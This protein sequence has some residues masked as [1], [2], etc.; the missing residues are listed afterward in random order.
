M[1]LTQLLNDGKFKFV[2]GLYIPSRS[3]KRLFPGIVTFNSSLNSNQEVYEQVQEFLKKYSGI[4]SKVNAFFLGSPTKPKS[5]T[6][7]MEDYKFPEEIT[8]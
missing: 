4:S 1:V 5:L 8:W 7:F 3:W 6:Y 2:N